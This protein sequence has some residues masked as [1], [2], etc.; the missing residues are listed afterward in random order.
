M[1]SYQ[2]IYHAGNRAD[3]QKHLWLIT[4]LDYLLKK[5]TPFQ[6]VDTHAGRG[7]YNLESDEAQKIGEF[8]EGIDALMP[9]LIKNQDAEQANVNAFQHYAKILK[10]LNGDGHIKTYPGSAYIAAK[11]MRP[12]DR[13]FAYDLHKGEYPYLEKTLKNFI[14]TKLEF[15]DGYH[16]LKGK[17]PP[18]L[19]R[20]GVL[21]D[22][23]YEIK[24]EYKTCIKNILAAY[25]KWPQGIYMIWYPI[26]P[27]Q[28]HLDM[29]EA[30]K[31]SDIPQD[32]II[33]DEWHFAPVERGMSG[34]GMI[35][36]NPPFTAE[37]DMKTIKTMLKSP[38]NL[39]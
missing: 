21:C 5:D 14:N 34:T 25:K 35:I 8:N 16:A 19:K 39:L 2:H 22:P 11:I 27:A 10:D 13:L 33:I 38:I 28:N 32:K 15:E 37:N 24:T 4:V 3:I 12:T 20:G 29:I 18:H 30:V 9:L 7:L 23:S 26:L 17:I 31:A 6:W 1:L 36:I